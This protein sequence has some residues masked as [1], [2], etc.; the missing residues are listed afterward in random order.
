MRSQICMISLVVSCT[1]S[2]PTIRLSPA[3]AQH[4]GVR[5]LRPYRALNG[6]A[7]MLV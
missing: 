6:A 3:S 1:S 5:H 4:K 2:G 7:F